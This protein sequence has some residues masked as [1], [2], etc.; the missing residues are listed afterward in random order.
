MTSQTKISPLLFFSFAIPFVYW[1]YLFFTTETQVIWDSLDYQ[2]LGKMLYEQGWR[3]FFQTGP[4][5]EPLYPFLVSL[6]MRTADGL[7]ASYLKVLII[8]QFFCLFLTQF[9]TL[10]ILQKLKVFELLAAVIIF[11]IG[12]SPALINTALSLYSEILL[13]PFIPAAVLLLNHSVK[14]LTRLSRSQII[15]HGAALGLFFLTITMIKGIFELLTPVLLLSPLILLRRHNARRYFALALTALVLFQTALFAYKALNKQHNG[16]FTLTNRGAW[17]LYGYSAR[18]TEPFDRDR[19]LSALAW[20]PG[21][22]VCNSLLGQEKCVYWSTTVSDSF[23]MEKLKELENTGLIGQAADR[24]MM[25]LTRERIQSNPVQYALLVG[26]E[27]FKIFFWESTRLAFVTYPGW[28]EKLFDA[29]IFKNGLRLLAGI[30]SFTAS[31]FVLI[32]LWRDRQKL[33]EKYFLLFLMAGIT[34]FY[35][36]AY[37][38]FWLSTRYALPLAPLFLVMIAYALSRIKSPR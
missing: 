37:S 2:Q 27:G 36:G 17:A 29:G 10:K 7:G 21:E 20:V 32:T 38:I 5:R 16:V 24:E 22:G 3:E 28:L 4:N 18:R 6:A 33:D 26:L 11:Y 1:V 23:G 13:L 8:A 30:F 14:N 25:R 34:F 19:W 31:V 15:F 9:F 12:I 35:T